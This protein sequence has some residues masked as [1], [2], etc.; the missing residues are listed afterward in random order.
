[1]SPNPTASLR[2]TRR[3]HRRSPVLVAGNKGKLFDGKSSFDEAAC[4]LMPEVMKME[5]V[6]IDPSLDFKRP[7]SRRRNVPLTYFPFRRT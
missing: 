5:V 4:A 2:N 3:V 7:S 6:A 1:M